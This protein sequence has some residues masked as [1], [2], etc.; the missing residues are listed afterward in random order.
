MGGV[1][2][3]DPNAQSVPH[4]T[5]KTPPAEHRAPKYG[6]QWRQNVILIGKWSPAP[7]PGVSYLTWTKILPITALSV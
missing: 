3:E 1:Q 7:D 6:Q 5:K 4:N 2:G